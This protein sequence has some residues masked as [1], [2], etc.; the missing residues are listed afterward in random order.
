[1]TIKSLVTLYTKNHPNELFKPLEDAFCDLFVRRFIEFSQNVA[2]PFDS[3]LNHSSYY[4][5]SHIRQAF[6]DASSQLTSLKEEPTDEPASKRAKLDSQQQNETVDSIYWSLNHSRFALEL[7][8]Q[9]VFTGLKSYFADESLVAVAKGL[10]DLAK[11]GTETSSDV[12]AAISAQ[13]IVRQCNKN[14]CKLSREQVDECLEVFED[15]FMPLLRSRDILASGGTYILETKKVLKKMLGDTFALMVGQKLSSFHARIFRIIR[16]KV[17]L[18]QKLIE[19]IAMVTPKE[20][21]EYVFD[22]V[23]AGFIKTNYYSRV[24]DYVPAKTYFVFTVD[25]DL[26][27]KRTFEECCQAIYNS[28]TR[29]LHEVEQ[30]RHL[31]DR[32]KYVDLQIETLSKEENSEQQI[33][34]LKSSF[35]THDLEVIQKAEESISKLEMAEM[36]VTNT[37]TLMMSWLS[38]Q[39]MFV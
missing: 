35:T 27:A 7:Q 9:L 17:S 12:T 37:M 6:Q 15:D 36:Q 30:N 29:R 20:C 8:Y 32:K 2:S 31:I 1:M 5:L 18:P 21:K 16:D 26:V 11:E 28:I 34:D 33:E 14:G 38:M 24:P 4:G 25:L 19:E 10:I 23:K 22:L 39:N 3:D 13:E